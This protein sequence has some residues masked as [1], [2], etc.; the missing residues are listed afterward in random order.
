MFIA[1][2][3]PLWS[4]S[5]TRLAILIRWFGFTTVSAF[6]GSGLICSLGFIVGVLFTTFAL[7]NFFDSVIVGQSAKMALPVLV[8]WLKNVI[9]EVI[10][11]FTESVSLPLFAFC[12]SLIALD[13]AI[14]LVA[15]CIT[16]P[17]VFA[18]WFL[19]VLWLVESLRIFVLV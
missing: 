10:V 1:L 8:F 19:N 7:S 13:H 17:W 5:C 14:V 16:L 9:L 15:A 3:A 6:A 2:R 18:S 12:A 11:W 4:L